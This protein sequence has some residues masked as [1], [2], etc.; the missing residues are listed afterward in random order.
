MTTSQKPQTPQP[1]SEK[2]LD[3]Y[4]HPAIPWSRAL[5]QLQQDKGISPT[6]W[7]ATVNPDGKPHVMAVWAVWLDGTFCFLSG[8]STRKGKNL[9]RSPYVVI[10]VASKGIDLVLEGEAVKVTDEAKLQRIA[11]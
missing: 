3:I 2:N 8:A 9:A 10:T 5:E 11:N 7:L 4:G 1:V 6:H